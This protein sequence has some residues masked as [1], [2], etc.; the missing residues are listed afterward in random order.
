ME[1]S[2]NIFLAFKNVEIVELLK[3]FKID[4][5][6]PEEVWDDETKAMLT[7]KIKEKLLS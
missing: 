7:K 1:K 2:T 5:E 6:V 3:K 4:Y